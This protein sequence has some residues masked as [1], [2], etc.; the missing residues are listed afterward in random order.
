MKMT[1]QF[2][3]LVLLCSLITGTNGQS[4]FSTWGYQLQNYDLEVLAQSEYDLLVIDYSNDGTVD[5]EFTSSEISN[6]RSGKDGRKIIS[7]ISIGEAE[8]YRFYWDDSWSSTAP[9]WLDQENSDWPG[10]YKVKYW[11]S[12]WQDIIK[13]YLQKIID[14]GFDG[15]YLDIID[16]Y[17]FFEA[18][19]PNSD[20][21]MIDFVE[22]ISNFTR[23]QNS[24]F[25]IIPQNGEAIVNSRYLDLVDG[26]AREEVYVQ[27]TNDKR[28]LVET[29][30]IEGYLDKFLDAG[31]IVM[32]VDYANN[33]DLIDYATTSA[34]A[35][36]YL[37]LV[38]DVDLDQLGPNISN[39]SD[40]SFNMVGFIILPI[41]II[42]SKRGNKVSIY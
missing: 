32:V 17:E 28:D 29:R 13:E 14:A 10:N 8:D 19:V 6:I 9:E 1:K 40:S 16:G 25:L 12:S 36:G 26:I 37:T 7:Y 3:L 27:S 11:I 42:I 18:S 4:N 2:V 5:E 20:E 15:I 35:K 31:K 33:E 30:E 34:T 39:E 23:E 21:L 41:I 24:E 22:V 38:T